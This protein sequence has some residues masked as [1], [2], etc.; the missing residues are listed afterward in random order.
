M[1]MTLVST[2]TVGAGGASSI[3]FTSIPQTGTDLLVVASL[4]GTSTPDFPVLV[5]NTD[6]SSSANYLYRDLYG[7]GSS[8][9]S[10]V[11]SSA[12]IEFGWNRTTT[13][14]TFGNVSAY[15]SNYT[16]TTSKS[17]SVD[18]VG[19]ANATAADQMIVAGRWTSTTG[20]TTLKIVSS[21]TF[22]QYSTASLYTITKGSG[23]ATVS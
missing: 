2:V 11:A 19:E 17:V 14:N 18:A 5:F 1:T 3:E 12:G 22:A 21:G 10:G 7:S 16:S 15:I 9:S 23:G 6:A 13:A 4:R 20:I 8:A